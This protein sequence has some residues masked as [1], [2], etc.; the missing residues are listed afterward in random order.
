VKLYIIK[1]KRHRIKLSTIY[2]PNLCYFV[3]VYSR[4]KLL[5][6]FRARKSSRWWT[7]I[8]LGDVYLF[9][10]L[11][12]ISTNY[13]FN[14][15]ELLYKLIVKQCQQQQQLS[16]L[17][18]V[19]IHCS[20]RHE[21]YC[22]YEPEGSLSCSQQPDIKLCREGNKFSRHPQIK[23]VQCPWILTTLTHVYFS[24]TEISFQIFLLNHH[25][26]IHGAEPFLRSYQLCSYSR[27]S[28]HFI[29]PEDS[30]PCSQESSTGL[31]PERDQ[32]NPYHH[33]LSL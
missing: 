13:S 15:P 18:R 6:I 5:P 19:L 1:L 8:Y 33:I 24:E 11:S 27:T 32:S 22:F 16:L 28:Q 4:F 2:S 10:H 20:P 26:L 25:S 14:Y 31:Y 17:S 3:C 29:E 30:L 12:E 23:S 21:F 9:S 7:R